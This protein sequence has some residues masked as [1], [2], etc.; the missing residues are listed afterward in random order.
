MKV[1]SIY[2]KRWLEKKRKAGYVIV[3]YVLPASI[4]EA[5]KEYKDFLVQKERLA[6]GNES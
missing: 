5:L 2:Q 4:K 6:N 1:E 3:Q